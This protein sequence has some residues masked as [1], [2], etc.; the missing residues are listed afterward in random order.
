MLYG[1]FLLRV[2]H[3]IHKPLQ[4]LSSSPARLEE[5]VHDLGTGDIK[6]CHRKSSVAIILHP[7]ANSSES[8]QHVLVRFRAA[9]TLSSR[10]NIR[11]RRETLS[12]A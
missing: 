6:Y 5:V 11:R 7:A 8:Q 3:E 4:S 9:R 1:Q 12:S 10:H 2:H